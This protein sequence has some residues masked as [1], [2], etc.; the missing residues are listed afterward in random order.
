MG[1]AWGDSASS[2]NF[3]L[4]ATRVSHRAES[5]AKGPNRKLQSARYSARDPGGFEIG[6]FYIGGE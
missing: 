1:S 3:T 6:R 2:K 5:D 4:P